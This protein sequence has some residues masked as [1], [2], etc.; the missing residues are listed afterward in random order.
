[1]NKNRYDATLI[2]ERSQT[3]HRGVRLP[4][5][6]LPEVSLESLLPESFLRKEAAE[7]PEVTELDVMRH[8][9][10]LSHKN[11]AIDVDFYPLGS[12]TMKY[13][14]KINERAA[15]MPGF[16]QVHPYQPDI[17]IQGCLRLLYELKSDL[18]EI[19]GLPGCSLQPAAGAHGEMTGMLM[20]RAYHAHHGQAARTRVLVPDNAHGT[21]PSSAAMC[22]YDVVTLRS[23]AKGQVDMAHLRELLDTQGDQIA[24]LMMTNPNT[25]GIFEENILTISEWVHAAGA[26]IYYD[27]ANLN[28]I[29][30]MARPGDMGFDVVHLN[31][32]K[33]FST[34]HGGGGPGA[35]PVL[36]RD[37][38]EPF[39]PCP[40]IN[41]TEIAGQAPHFG[42]D[43][44]RPLSI[45]RVR[46]FFG[47]FGVLVRAWTYIRAMG[48][49]GLKQA[50]QD[51]VLNAN[52]V[53]QALRKVYEL[54]HGEGSCMH[55]FV[56]SAQEMKKQYGVNALSVAKRL[57]DF[58]IHP[59][60]VYFPLIVPEA[61]MIEPTETESKATL[62]RFIQ[63]MEK[64]AEES[65]TNP[66]FVN[67]SPHEALIKRVDEAGANRKPCI[68]W[69]QH[70][71][72]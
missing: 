3:G 24:A 25:L 64:I 65:A 19:V 28:A 46:S 8:F 29:M 59:P 45:G 34:P 6:P 38:L 22:G 44:E 47:N 4:A 51:A 35:G 10:T 68:N 23:N 7:L 72:V 21:N 60:T 20:I 31:L 13:N 48:P 71:E 36:V 61:L 5:D 69:F 1:M 50:S 66:D 53:R 63:V 14:P 16:S 27:G 70:K 37:I 26:L 41:K 12:C 11:H 43:R 18:A 52:Y 54:P 17:Q 62:D 40:V 57:I 39:L 49:E 32:H 15:S 67:A 9:I 2:F 30:G 55:E 58:G 33:T 56:L 42:V